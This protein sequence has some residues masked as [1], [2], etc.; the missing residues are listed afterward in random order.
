VASLLG[1]LA[2]YGLSATVIGSIA[3]GD[4]G[5]VRVRFA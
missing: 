2:D 4:P 5:G 3:S 1:H